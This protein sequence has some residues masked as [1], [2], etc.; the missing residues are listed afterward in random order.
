MK[1]DY[2]EFV[3]LATELVSEFGRPVSLFSTTRQPSDSTKPWNGPQVWD[4]ATATPEQLVQVDAVFIGDLLAGTGGTVT[5]SVRS[6]LGPFLTN[7]GND[8]FLVSG[9]TTVELKNFDKL[10]DNNILW[11][12]ESVVS[13][14]PGDTVVLYAIKVSQ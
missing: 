9:S 5:G 8:I 14:K 6:T 1:F 7:L 3:E 10:L 2:T 4:D 13:V 12:I 11:N